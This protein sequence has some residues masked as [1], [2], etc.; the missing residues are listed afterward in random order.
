MDLQSAL[1]TAG[2]VNEAQLPEPVHEEADSRTSGYDHLRQGFLTDLGD[3]GFRNAL[4]AE[5]SEL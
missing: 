3:N 1:C 5:M 2:V 4:F